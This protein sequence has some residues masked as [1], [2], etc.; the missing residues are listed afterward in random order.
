MRLPILL[1]VLAIAVAA[2]ARAD[3]PR[4][5]VFDL[6]L[7]D[8]SLEAA[9]GENPDQT[10]RIEIATAELRRL[11]AESGQVDLVELSPKAEE[12][13]RNAPLHRCNGCEDEIARSLGAELEVVSLVQKTSN[14]ILN[15]SVAIKDLRAEKVIRAGSVDI[16]GNNDEMWLRGV[17]WLVKNRLLATPIAADR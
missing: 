10:H 4:T 16:R 14:L 7:I 6:E 11:L 1:S 15:F 17:R 5:V 2:D 8:M 3:S 9:R 12:I 13:R